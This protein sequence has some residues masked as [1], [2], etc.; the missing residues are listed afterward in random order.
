MTDYST[1]GQGL[2]RGTVNFAKNISRSLTKPKQK[3]VADMIYGIIASGSCKLTE[4]GCELKEGTR[5]AKVSERLGRNLKSLSDTKTLM[6]DYIA[7][8]RP[9]IGENTMLILDPSDVIKPSSPKMEG[10]GEIYDASEQTFGNGYWTIGAVALTEEHRQPIPVYERLYPCKKQGGNGSG[11]E[12]RKA[13][14]HLRTHFSKDIP[15]IIDRG[16][17]SGDIIKDLTENGEKFIIRVNQNRAAVHGGERTYINDVVKGL[18]CTHNFSYKN[19]TDEKFNCKI[20]MTQVI[21]PYIGNTKLNIVAVK[22]LKDDLVLYTNLDE[23]L[24]NIAERVVKA[25]LMRWRIEEFYEFK[26]QRWG[27][28]DFRVRSLVSIQALDILLTIASGYVAML[29]EKVDGEA[30]VLDLIVVSG[31]IDKPFAFIRKKKFYLYAILDGVQRVLAFLRCGIKGFFVKQS[32]PLQYTIFD[33][34]KVG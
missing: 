6:A 24:E 22:G 9:S 30:Y 19:K 28:E 8:I 18:D 34:Q 17:D 1:L 10:I 26:K 29:S 21:L 15:R 32:S 23:N 31:R 5:L 12:M 4:I 20:G 2:K 25:Y 16:F 7:A 3:F 27:W 14:E 13:L 11:V 33:L